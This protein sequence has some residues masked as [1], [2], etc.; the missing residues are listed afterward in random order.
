[1]LAGIAAAAVALGVTELLAVAFGPAGRRPHRVGSAVIDLTPGPVKEW[2]IQTF[3]T[4]DKL[5]L[6]ILVLVV[7]AVVAAVTARV[8]DA[9]RSG[10]QRRD[11][12]RR[13][14]RV[15]G[16]PLARGRDDARH[17]AHRGRHRVRRRR[18]AAAHLGAVHRRHGPTEGSGCPRSGPTTVA[19]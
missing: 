2:A 10:R 13:N 8:R 1:M 3:G 6:S 12:A 19:W 9:S 16:G 4:A 18:A 11:R 15:C 14:R 17:R 5:V 7:I